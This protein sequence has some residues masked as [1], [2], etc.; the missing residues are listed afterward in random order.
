MSSRTGPQFPE[1]PVAI[2]NALAPALAEGRVQPL[3]MDLAGNVRVLATFSG[4]IGAVDQGSP[5]TIANGWPVKIT[6][7]TDLLLINGSGEAEM[8][9]ARWLGSTAPT[10]GQKVMASSLPVVLASNQS[11]VPVTGTV[12]ANQG[13]ANAAPWPVAEVSRRSV[14]TGVY[15][16]MGF[17]APGVAAANRFFSLFNPAGSGR[18]V[19]AIRLVLRSY[20]VAVTTAKNS[21]RI[22]SIT[23]ASAGTLQAAATIFKHKSS[24]ANNAAE[25]R[26]ANPTVTVGTDFN[27]WAP[28]VIITAAGGYAPGEGGA[29]IPRFEEEEIQLAEGEGIALRMAGAGDVDMTFDFGLTWMETNP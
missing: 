18:T 16:Y 22:C 7:G 20:A 28:P 15:S 2:S 4:A 25:L 19:I 21:M 9:L 11:A 1:L 8:E 29:W 14:I 24:Y 6:D 27:G 12:T 13:T 26:T 23:A 5:N 17:D 3:S 10:V